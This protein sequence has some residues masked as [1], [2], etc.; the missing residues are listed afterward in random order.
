[1]LGFWRYTASSVYWWRQHRHGGEDPSDWM[2]SGAIGLGI[3]A[4]LWAVVLL[5][6]IWA[7]R[8]ITADES[9]AALMFSGSF[10]GATLFSHLLIRKS[11]EPRGTVASI[12]RG[13]SI[14][15]AYIVG[16]LVVLVLVI[17]AHG[18]LAG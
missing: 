12:R 4:N 18:R 2:A 13:A 6:E 17:V 5:V 15:A 3:A 11:I 1:M 10:L 14:A 8:I 16:S 7:G 9:C